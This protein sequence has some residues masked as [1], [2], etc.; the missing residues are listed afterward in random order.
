MPMPTEDDPEAESVRGLRHHVT[1][2]LHGDARHQAGARQR[3]ARDS[4]RVPLRVASDDYF[5]K[6]NGNATDGFWTA[7]LGVVVTSL[8]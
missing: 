2:H 6:A 8:P 4:P 7:V 1:Q 5:A 3:G